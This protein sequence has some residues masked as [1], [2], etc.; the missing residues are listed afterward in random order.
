V[1][2]ILKGKNGGGKERLCL[3]V[4]FDIFEREE[5]VKLEMAKG[6]KEVTMEN[7]RFV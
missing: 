1:E 4:R 2:G 5:R 7:L 3:K 6:A